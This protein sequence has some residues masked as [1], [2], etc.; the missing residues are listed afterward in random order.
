MRHLEN[1]FGCG[2]RWVSAG[3][4]G[5]CLGFHL[6]PLVVTHVASVLVCKLANG[7]Y[8]FCKPISS[9]IYYPL[10]G[11]FATLRTF[12]FRFIIYGLFYIVQSVATIAAYIVV[13]HL[14]RPEH[15][16]I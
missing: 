11:V 1:F 7:A 3:S 10:K 16:V 14:S 8:V 15:K 5:I 6:R 12:F 2:L 13:K 4:A 9:S